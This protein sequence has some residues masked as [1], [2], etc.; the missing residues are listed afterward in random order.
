[1]VVALRDDRI[2]PD[3]PEQ[4]W[5]TEVGGRGW[6]VR[7][8]GDDCSLYAIYRPARKSATNRFTWR[9]LP[10]PSATRLNTD[11]SSKPLST[12]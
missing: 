10:I 3:C 8:R 4:T 5:L 12:K 6:L 1:M 2:A 11:S 9:D 7:G